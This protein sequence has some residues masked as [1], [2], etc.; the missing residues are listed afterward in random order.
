MD[1]KSTSRRALKP[2][3]EQKPTQEQ[4]VAETPP[5]Y[6]NNVF[7]LTAQGILLQWFDKVPHFC[8]HSSTTTELSKLAYLHPR[9]KTI[10]LHTNTFQSCDLYVILL[11]T[12]WCFASTPVLL[13]F[14]CIL[15]F[16]RL[17]LVDNWYHML[18]LL[19]NQI[20]CQVVEFWVRVVLEPFCVLAFY[21]T[22]WFDS[23]T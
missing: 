22:G 16:E 1:T 15:Q 19:C 11:L 12:P 21:P 13:K 8:W 4:E 5:T 10:A 20:T 14:Y 18:Q 17:V 6:L 9:D 3:Q 2:A 7:N 23:T